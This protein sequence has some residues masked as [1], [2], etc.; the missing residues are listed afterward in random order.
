MNRDEF[1]IWKASRSSA[2]PNPTDFD[3]WVAATTLE[4][5]RCRPAVW[6]EGRCEELGKLQDLLHEVV[7]INKG[8]NCLGRIASCIALAESLTK[9][10]FD[11]RRSS[12]K[13]FLLERAIEG[14][15]SARRP[16][17]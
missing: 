16:N 9:M 10:D 1:N 8:S 7:A 3:A 13:Q 4:R 14:S 11:S 17:G 2:L 5:E 6:D 15:E 12:F